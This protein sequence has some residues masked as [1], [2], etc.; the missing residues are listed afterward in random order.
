VLPRAA[1]SI[2]RSTCGAAIRLLARIGSRI[3]S[4]L[5]DMRARP[6][7]LVAGVRP[8]DDRRL[9]RSSGG[10]LGCALP[11]RFQSAAVDE[12]CIP[13]LLR[14]EAVEHDPDDHI[15]HANISA[16]HVEL[17]KKARP[18]RPMLPVPIPAY[19]AESSMHRN[20]TTA[21]R[22]TWLHVRSCLRGA[23]WSSTRPGPKCARSN[24]ARVAAVVD[25]EE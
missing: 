22:L 1:E 23:A 24:R 9:S 6:R 13:H 14:A 17:A 5:V 10:V 15:F 25:R 12:R 7:A 3:G 16:C 21:R 11:R 2:D 20:G 8:Q 19:G 4:P 18:N